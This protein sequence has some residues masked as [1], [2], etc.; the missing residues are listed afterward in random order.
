MVYKH[1]VYLGAKGFKKEYAKYFEKFGKVYI[2]SE[3]DDGSKQFIN[4]ISAILP[5]NK[6]FVITSKAL[7]SNCKDISDLHIAGKLDIKALFA[8]AKPLV[9]T[10]TNTSVSVTPKEQ[11]HVNIGKQ[12]I[13]KLNLKYY[14]NQLYTYKDGAYKVADGK[15]LKN[16]I[17]REIDI[18]AKK[19]LCNEV[20][21]LR[22]IGYQ[23]IMKSL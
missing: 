12:L 18:N 17:I 5:I 4:G 6:L 1:L 11:S 23:M 20:I 7:D 19:G 9:N 16:C 3:E 21:E 14:N 22:K 8:T 13:E 10:L 15:L 2:H